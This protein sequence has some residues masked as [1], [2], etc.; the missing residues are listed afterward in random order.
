MILHLPLKGILGIGIGLKGILGIVIIIIA[1]D[2][3]IPYFVV[4]LVIL[5]KISCRNPAV[6]PRGLIINVERLK[7]LHHGR[8]SAHV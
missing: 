7:L 1:C 8:A 5:R 2:P 6:K 3:A 4:F